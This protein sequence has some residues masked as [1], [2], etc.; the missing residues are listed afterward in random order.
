MDH[1]HRGFAA[2]AS[3]AAAVAVPKPE[4]EREET[5]AARQ[6]SRAAFLR[7]AAT[8]PHPL[9][10]PHHTLTLVHTHVLLRSWYI[11]DI[12]CMF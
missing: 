3:G 7:I 4:R 12:F 2:S 11:P 1:R 5:G 6:L 9:T 10:L 8:F